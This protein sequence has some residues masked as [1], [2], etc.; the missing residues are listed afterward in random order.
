MALSLRAAAEHTGTRPSTI[1]RAILSGRLS[2]ERDEEGAYR[3]DPEELELLF[4]ADRKVEPGAVPLA[5]L[6]VVPPASDAAKAG[7]A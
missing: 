2:V 6:R 7:G 1:L 3:L 5:R 4:S